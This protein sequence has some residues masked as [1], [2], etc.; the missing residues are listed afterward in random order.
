[1]RLRPPFLDTDLERGRTHLLPL[2]NKQKKDKKEK[3]DATVDTLKDPFLFSFLLTVHL[4][5][6]GP[7]SGRVC[8]LIHLLSLEYHLQVGPSMLN[9]FV[10]AGPSRLQACEGVC[11]KRVR[12]L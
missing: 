4:C 3:V 7:R 8:T 5:S 9:Y 6:C 11:A 10:F 2:H 1:M 12:A